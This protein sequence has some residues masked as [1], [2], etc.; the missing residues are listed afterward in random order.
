M[1]T[2]AVVMTAHNRRD[3][4]IAAVESVLAQV[5]DEGEV[6]VFLTDDGSTDG[7]GPAVSS[8]GVTV[9]NG[10]G[11]LFW[12]GGMAMA[13]RAAWRTR[14]DYLLWLNDDT[15]LDD[16]AL[17][18]MVSV[19]GAHPGVV[20]GATR[21]PLT[22]Q[23]TYG[24]RRRESSWHPQRFSQVGISEHVQPVD[25]FNGNVVLVPAAV[26][27]AVGPIDDGF[28]HAYADDDYGLRVVERG[29][30]ISQ[31]PGTVGSCRRSRNEDQ[32]ARGLARWRALQEPKGLPWR[33]QVRFL[34]RHG[35]WL[36]PF[37]AIGQQA[38]AL[39]GRPRPRR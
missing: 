19:E 33:A 22:G 3:I 17:H 29:F 13:E 28:P 1:T 37:I 34:R 20:V 4:T 24:G 12:A 6:A 25:T 9:V 39:I 18:R 31:A 15:L 32:P 8:L 16:D 11:Q 10:D 5:L 21:D 26:R 7:T 2:V 36:W 27:E 14:P 23:L 35:N 38:G 30:R